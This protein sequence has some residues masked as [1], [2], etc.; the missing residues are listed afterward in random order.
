[1]AVSFPRNGRLKDCV[2]QDVDKW[3]V[4]TL[5][6]ASSPS[7]FDVK[8]MA[9][10]ELEPIHLLCTPCRQGEHCLAYQDDKPPSQVDDED[11]ASMLQHAIC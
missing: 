5:P 8:V 10:V 9:N 6:L 2:K 7:R 3:L 11:L 4:T 1:M